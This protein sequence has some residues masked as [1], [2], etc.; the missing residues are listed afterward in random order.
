MNGKS[1]LIKLSNGVQMPALSLGVLRSA[2]KETAAAVETA[3]NADY[4]LID[5]ASVYLNEPEAGEGIRRSGISRSDIFVTT[6]LW[7]THYGYESALRAFDSSL[8]KLGLDYLDLYLAHWPVPAAFDATIDSYRAAEKLLAERRVRAIGVCNFSSQH[9]Q[10]LMERT[11]AR[12]AVNQI[13]LH[14]S[15]SQRELREADA[16][17]GITT[18]SWSPIGGSI[19]RGGDAAKDP[20]HHPT[21]L[22]LGAKYSKTPVQI[23]LRWHIDH[24]LSA[25]PSPFDGNVLRKT[26]TF[27]ISQ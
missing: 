11:Q 20:L 19:R 21:I 18:Q 4:R 14:P 17:L 2:K 15:F 13:E 6:K 24:R 23:V 3:I 22:Q 7:L 1:S 9:L 12:P 26:S 8:K 5:T 25:I 10:N 16:R 27:S